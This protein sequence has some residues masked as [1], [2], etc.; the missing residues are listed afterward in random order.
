MIAV[1]KNVIVKLINAVPIFRTCMPKTAEKKHH[2]IAHELL[3]CEC[4]QELTQ[5]QCH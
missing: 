3:V 5:V 4:G 2:F 1:S